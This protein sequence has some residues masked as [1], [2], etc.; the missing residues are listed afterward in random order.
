MKSSLLIA[1]ICLGFGLLAAAAESEIAPQVAERLRQLESKLSTVKT[2]KVDFVQEKQMAI[3]E[4]KLVLKGRISLQQPD[5][6]AW[7]VQSPIR[8]AMMIQGATLRQWSEDTQAVQQFSLGGNPVFSAAVKQIQSWFSGNYLALTREFKVSLLSESPLA[9]EFTPR[10][11]SPAREMIS[12]IVMRFGP[13]ERFLK[14]LE[15]VESGGDTM[16]IAFSNTTLNPVLP[17]EEWNPRHE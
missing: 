4:Q 17:K 15:V 7:R 2:L 16:R 11:G 12:R 8:Y 1:A 13:D 3:L 14:S 5:K 9:F 6:I 10:A